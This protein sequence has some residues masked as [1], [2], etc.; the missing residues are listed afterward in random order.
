MQKYIFSAVIALLF[1]FTGAWSASAAVPAAPVLSAATAGDAQ[2][3]LSWGAVSGATGYSVKVGTASG[4]Y[5]AINDVGNVTAYTVSGLTNGTKYY[6]VATANNVSGASVNSNEINATPV[7]VVPVA[8][9]LNAPSAANNQVTLSWNAVPWATGYT[10]KMGTTAGVYSTSVNV[11]NVTTY[12]SSGL[13]NGTLYYF[14]VSAGN[15]AGTSANSAE[16]SATPQLAI[17]AAPVVATFIAGNAQASLTW[18]AVPGATSYSV[19]Y[20]TTAGVYGPTVNVGNVTSFTIANLVN[21]TVYYAVV[22]AANASGTSVNSN[23]KTATPQLTAPAAPSLSYVTP[24]YGQL[25]AGWAAIP[26]AMGYTVKCGTTPGVYTM[27]FTVGNVTAY[28]IPGLTNGAVYYVAVSANNAAGTSVNSNERSGVPQLPAPVL[29]SAEGS[30]GQVT[31]GWS[32]LAGALS[33]S[34]KYGT[35]A[36]TYTT[37]VNAGNITSFTVP[38]LTDGTKYYFAVIAVNPLGNSA[39]SNEKSAMPQPLVPATPVLNTPV[40]GNTQV[41]LSWSPI[42]W[43]SGYTIKYG[44]APGV[45]SATFNVG[46]TTAYTVSGLTNATA[47]YFTVTANNAGGSSANAAERTAVPQVAI[48]AVPALNAPVSGNGQAIVSW[49][50]VAGATGYSVKYGTLSGSYGAPVSVGNVT[51]YTIPGLTNGVTYYV[52]VTASNA[53]GTSANAAEKAVVPQLI[54]PVAPVLNTAASGNGQVVLNW[55]AVPGATN[56]TV[57]YGL[58]VTTGNVTSYTLTGLTNGLPYNVVITATSSSGTSISSN[59]RVVTPQESTLAAP[60]LNGPVAGYKQLTL[61]WSA[62]SG[63][64]GYFVKYGTAAGVYTTT[65][66]AGTA[67]TYT[68]TGLTNGT[69]YYAVVIASNATTVS[70]NS[71]ETT[72]AP[73]LPAPVAPVLASALAGN[74]QI[75]LSWGAVSGATGYVVKYGTVTGVYTNT[76]SVGSVTNYVVPGLN[77]ATTYYAVVSAINASGMSIN[78]NEKSATPL[79]SVPAAPVL[80]APTLSNGQI[81]LS[82]NN[83]PWATRYTVKY[84]T[85][86]GTYT[87]TLDVGNVTGYTI[88]GLSNGTTYYVVVVANNDLGA[89]PASLEKSAVPMIPPPVLNAPTVSSGQVNLSWSAVPGALTYTVRYGTATGVYT[90]TVSVGNVTAFTVS[91]LTNAATY[92]FVVAATTPAGAGANS[93]EKSATAQ[94]AVPV[95]PSLNV[96][97]PMN[98]QLSLSWNGVPWAATY[99][100][101][102]GTAPGVYGTSVDVGNVTSFNLSGLMNGTTYYVVV[103]AVNTTGIS[104]V[105]NER[106]A[107]PLLPAPVLNTPVTGSTQVT[108]SWAAVG[109]ANAYTLKYGTATGVYTTTVNVGNVTSYTVTGLTNGTTY[110][111]VLN[112]VNAIGTSV[113]SA[114]KSAVPQLSVPAVPVLNAPTIGNGQ[115]TLT[116]NDVAWAK[117]YKVSYGTSTGVYSTSRNVGNVTSFTVPALTNGMT[118]YFTV[119]S[120]N[121]VGSSANAAEKSAVPLAPPAAPVVG[122]V[123]AGNG[124]AVINWSAVSTASSYS[125]KYGTVTGVYPSTANT[126]NVTNTTLTG[127]TNGRKYYFVVTASNASGTSGFSLEKTV[128]PVAPPVAYITH[129]TYNAM[130]QKTRVQYGNGV[131]TAYTYDPKNYRLTRI[132]T[133]NAQALVLQDLNYKYDALGQIMSITDASNTGSQTFKYDALNRLSQANGKYGMKTYAYDQVGNITTKDG[134]TYRYG[135]TNSRTDGTKAGPHAVTSLSDGSAFKYDANGNMVSIVKPEKTTTYSYDAQNR[136]TSV[137]N[138]AVGQASILVAEYKYDGDGGRT[139]KTVYRRDK[140]AYSVMVDS[141]LFYAYG[142]SLPATAAN[143]TVE[144]T[145]YVGNIYE[146]NGTRQT[147]YIYL[148]SARVAASD[149]NGNIF[150]Y[151]TD[152]LGS[153]NVL[154]D[155]LG[156]QRE[157]TEYDPFGLVVRHD[158]GG[159]ANVMPWHYFTGKTLDDESGLMYY[160]A[161]YYNPKLGRFITP[162]TIVQ[163]PG[164]PQTLNRYTYCNN[165]PVNLIDPTGHSWLKSLQRVIGNMNEEIGR[166]VKQLEKVTGSEWEINAEAGYSSNSSSNR[167][168]NSQSK[169]NTGSS[170]NYYSDDSYNGRS[171][172]SYSIFDP[173]LA[174]LSAGPYRSLTVDL[175]TITVYADRNR[176]RDSSPNPLDA[177][178]FGLDMAGMAPGIGIFADVASGAISFGRGNYL[179]FG[180]S[181]LSA[182]PFVGD[183]AGAGRLARTVSSSRTI[184]VIGNLED[185]AVAKNWVGHDVLSLPSHGPNKWSPQRNMSWVDEGIRNRQPFYK[186]SPENMGNIYTEQGT[187]RIYGIELDRVR[188]SPGYKDVGDYL[189]P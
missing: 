141:T 145:R 69:R 26:W 35:T 151:H 57:K 148:G 62:V 80:N 53:G 184:K 168:N 6:I 99:T 47:Y 45:Y 15:A 98:T 107:V 92:Y 161:R 71:N 181:M 37:V 156:L 114:E 14:A 23:E 122:T 166:W 31:L 129:V 68:L 13:T 32:A 63:A 132:Y 34:I 136:L 167:T 112:A 120:V 72:A 149:N 165:N 38:G 105:S 175:G 91:G 77:N 40:I 61:T 7:I 1:S 87:T 126:A 100:I 95:A 46:N 59:E 139:K 66:N 164:N 124:Q 143:T 54:V 170:D 108:L 187:K 93:N 48:P 142:F 41:S 183:V 134:L 82:W 39:N 101:K 128:T 55:N 179:G 119:A 96:P 27:T 131:S 2:L 157:L 146:D 163:S 152:H 11:G 76:A 19:K 118:Y 52:T 10:L 177:V 106:S 171:G 140:A 138:A 73:Q 144:T 33:Y 29:N 133:V 123:T 169:N 18:S 36:A 155:R 104:P 147:K 97:T 3:K 172:Y 185:T 186:A 81:S 158:L 89:S 176:D 67:L 64:T 22:T 137:R 130:G 115:I 86:A 20:G 74:G 94:L 180:L 51:T 58:S 116:W 5:G 153:T 159:S 162:D 109:G 113:L 102:Y 154:T 160:G 56:Y 88:P 182:V 127:L 12:T 111:F 188:S 44:T 25:T 60:V 121:T 4:V 28:T 8:P 117:S 84:G 75:N 65:V 79:P 83:V 135:E 78:S 189:L 17:P 103:T 85:T 174:R 21:A 16:K 43:A 24:G 110:Y 50:E 70:S 9:V 90:T 125:I 42:A 49:A 150:A 30:K 173:V 178:Q